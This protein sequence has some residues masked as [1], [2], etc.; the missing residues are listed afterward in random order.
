MSVYGQ[1]RTVVTAIPLLPPLYGFP[2]R[3]WLV[4]VWFPYTNH[5]HTHTRQDAGARGGLPALSITVATLVR[6]LQSGYQSTTLGKFSDAVVKF[7]SILLNIALLALDTKSEI[8][9]VGVV[10]GCG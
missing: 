1:S 5:T 7:Q 2:Q 10:G 6:R 4:V 8:Q 9:E 3:N